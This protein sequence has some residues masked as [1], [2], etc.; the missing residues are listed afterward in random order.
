MT[1]KCRSPGIISRKSSSLLP[2]SS[3]YRSDRPVTLPPGPSQ[4]GDLAAPNRVR[5]QRDDDWNDGSGLHQCG[6]GDAPRNDNI[7]L[8]SDELSGDLGEAVATSL[9]P[10]ILDRDCAVLDPSE[11]RQSFDISS[12]PRPPD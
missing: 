12:S 5:P 1:A 3:V 4:T 10:A 6:Y 7:N 8:E 9:R 2:A 11:L